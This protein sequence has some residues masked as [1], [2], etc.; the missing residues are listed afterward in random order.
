MAQ[1]KIDEVDDRVIPSDKLELTPEEAAEAEAQARAAPDPTPKPT[2]F[3]EGLKNLFARK[4]RR[5]QLRAQA[6]WPAQDAD[7]VDY[8]HLSGSQVPTDVTFQLT[9]DDIELVL[10]SNRFDPHGKFRGQDGRPD[11]VF[12]IAVRGL[13]LGNRNEVGTIHAAENLAAVEVTDVRPDHKNFRCVIGFYVR[14]ADP[15]ARRVT[16]FSGS[17]VPNAYYMADYRDLV[18]GHAQEPFDKTNMLPTG[19]YVCRVDRHNGIRPALRM[20]DSNSLQRDAMCTVVR[21]H[22]DLLFNMKDFWDHCTP[23]DNVH[24]AYATSYNPSWLASFSS[25]GC[26]TVRGKSSPTDQWAKFQAILDRVGTSRRCDLVLITGRDLAIAAKLRQ[27][28]QDDALVQR[29]LVRL[30]PGS[31]G[32]E[33]RRLRAKL[34]IADGTYFGSGVKKKLADEQARKGVPVDGIYTPQ[35]DAKLGWQVFGPPVS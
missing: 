8:H 22:N 6:Q 17:T 12:A 27:S 3:L 34:G 10:R 2:T 9:P 23:Y 4:A 24:C 13:C 5:A 1:Q 26:L 25:R 35:L 14:T 28:N 29:E 18:V 31:S 30:R 11:E 33:V 21:T 7:A 19:C 32:E 15:N 20:S 16:L